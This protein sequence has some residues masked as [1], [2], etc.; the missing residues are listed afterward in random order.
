[1]FIAG[2]L[3]AAVLAFILM[4]LVYV[5]SVRNPTARVEKANKAAIIQAA[6]SAILPLLMPAILIVG[7]KFGIA[8]PTEVS[9]VAVLYGILLCVLVYRSIGW[10]SFVSIAVECTVM[11][12]MVLFI[13]AAAGSFAWIM[14]A[15]NVPQYLASILHALGDNRY[16][17]LAG[18]ILILIIVGSLLEGLPALIILGPILYPMA[19]QLGIDGVHYAMVLLLSM[20]VGIFMPPL[21]IGFYV[22]CS[23]MGTSVEQTSKAIIPYIFALLL[24]IFAVAAVPFFSLALLNAFGR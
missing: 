16:F 15:G 23:V 14:A 24:G 4:V 1:M 17:F 12:G 5:M 18:S 3:P 11:S 6:L 10:S 19:T 9:S 8:T 20:G 13:I 21:G 2:L 22:A 7:I